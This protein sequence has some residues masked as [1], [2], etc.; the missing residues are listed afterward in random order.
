MLPLH[1]H[2][3]EKRGRGRGRYA[4]C[5]FMLLSFGCLPASHCAVLC[6]CATHTHPSFFSSS[7]PLCGIMHTVHVH[8]CLCQCPVC[9]AHTG[10]EK[11]GGRGESGLFVLLF[12]VCVTGFSPSSIHPHPHESMCSV[13]VCVRSVCVGCMVMQSAQQQVKRSEE[14]R[15]EERRR[16][17]NQHKQKNKRE[18]KESEK[19]AQQKNKTEKTEKQRCDCS[20]CRSVGGI[21]LAAQRCFCR[22]RSYQRDHARSRL[23]LIV[24][25]KPVWARSVLPWVTRWE[26]RVMLL[27]L[28]FSSSATLFCLFSFFFLIS[29][30][31]A[32]ARSLLQLV[33][34]LVG[35]FGWLFPSLPPHTHALFFFGCAACTGV[36]SA[37]T[38]T[39]T[40][41]DRDGWL[42]NTLAHKQLIMVMMA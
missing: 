1:V 37:Y 5:L 14:R 3:E 20:V 40:H 21:Q 28:F 19:R 13:N 35:S 33:G 42:E 12:C 25:A 31:H 18:R 36:L 38:N 2:A 41:T 29:S 27:S 23:V 6:W 16:A 30:S 4:P 22:Q 15:G 24:E 39:H 8:A 11:E 9:T 26:S 17:A 32:H 7:P 34:W 10:R